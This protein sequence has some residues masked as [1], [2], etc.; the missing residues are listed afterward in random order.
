MIMEI[1][2]QG[3]VIPGLHIIILE[4]LVAVHFYRRKPWFQEA[5]RSWTDSGT[6]RELRMGNT[7][8]L[9]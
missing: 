8:H 3:T 7:V 6:A 9:H 1:S 2:L 5:I 4:V